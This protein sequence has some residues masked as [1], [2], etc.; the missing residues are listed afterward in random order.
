MKLVNESLDE[1]INNKYYLEYLLND[2]NEEFINEGEK[3]DAFKKKL[4]IGVAKGVITAAMI[5]TLMNNN[6]FSMEQKQEIKNII[7]YELSQQVEDVNG[8]VLTSGDGDSDF[9]NIYEINSP[10]DLSSLY[11]QII[12]DFENN[13]INKNL[14]NNIHDIIY[15]N[16][17]TEDGNI[18]GDGKWITAADEL[19]NKLN[20][21]ASEGCTYVIHAKTDMAKQI[22]NNYNIESSSEEINYE[23]KIKIEKEIQNKN[24]VYGKDYVPQIIE[25]G[26]NWG[27]KKIIEYLEYWN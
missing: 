12:K 9:N 16:I 7:G 20:I 26:D 11:T 6:A 5:I 27:M 18:K 23:D 24:G 25:K 19:L 14:L 15:K 17:I 21:Y 2:I 13:N 22:L 4:K 10:E 3:W 1:Y 8:E